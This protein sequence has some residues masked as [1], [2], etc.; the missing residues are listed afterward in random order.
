M[1]I[2][3]PWPAVWNATQVD[4]AKRSEDKEQREDKPRDYQPAEDFRRR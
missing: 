4:L 1:G 3:V 2:A